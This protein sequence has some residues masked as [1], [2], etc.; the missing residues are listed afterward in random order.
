MMAAAALAALDYTIPRLPSVHALAKQTAVALREM[1]YTIALPVQTNMIVL[2]LKADGIPAAAFV[3]YGKRAGV[4][5]F[6]SGRL[7]FHH[8][9]SPQAVEKLI[10]ALRALMEDKKAGKALPDYRVT[11]GYH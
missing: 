4:T 11:G 9:N 8:Q 6:P 3:E 2:D 5:L 7:V 10:S 1:G